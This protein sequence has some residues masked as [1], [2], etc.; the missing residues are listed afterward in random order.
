M[1]GQK[2]ARIKDPGQKGIAV[3]IALIMILVMSV[4][5]LSLMFVSNTDFQGM[6][7]FK[8]GHEAFLA[9]ERC[10]EEGRFRVE[11]EGFH[12][13]LFQQQEGFKI[14]LGDG[15]ANKN[16]N[17]VCRTGNR[18][19]ESAEDPYLSIT[20]DLKAKERPVE[21]TSVPSGN[22]GG[23]MAIPLSFNVM[24][25]YG[26]DLDIVDSN[27]NINTGTELAIGVEVFMPTG[28]GSNIY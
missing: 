28:V 10:A 7:A 14:V 3:F 13:L 16:I 23:A 6:Q 20:P 15:N 24:G 12:N 19:D 9:A 18:K 8:R 21:N 26:T 22:V 5:G 25:K 4:M 17:P 27:P 2:K 1:N 11:L